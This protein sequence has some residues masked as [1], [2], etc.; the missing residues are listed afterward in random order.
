MRKS[1]RS[2][3]LLLA[4]IF[5]VGML[6]RA[7]EKYIL[8]KNPQRYALD[9]EFMA[10]GRLGGPFHTRSPEEGG[11]WSNDSDFILKGPLPPL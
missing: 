4:L 11:P 6:P 1:V 8:N 2:A 9:S 7:A 5:A 3:I 10:G